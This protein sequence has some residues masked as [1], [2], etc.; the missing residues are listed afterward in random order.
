M[1]IWHCPS[2]SSLSGSSPNVLRVIDYNYDMA[3]NI[4]N[5]YMGPGLD[6][7]SGPQGNLGTVEVSKPLPLENRQLSSCSKEKRHFYRLPPISMR[8]RY[9]AILDKYW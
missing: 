6:M 2:L 3:T 9:L 7:T 5:E 4:T 1:E 8:S